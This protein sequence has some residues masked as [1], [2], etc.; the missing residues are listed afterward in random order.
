MDAEQPASPADTAITAATTAPSSP[1]QGTDPVLTPLSKPTWAL[2]LMLAWPV[3]AYQLL[4][5]VVGLSD[6]FL[7]GYFP[8][9]P[10]PQQSEALGHQLMAVGLF[11]APAPGSGVAAALAA[12]TPA[13]AARHIMAKQV[14]YQAAQTT[15]NYLAW[16]R[17]QLHRSGQR[18]QHGPG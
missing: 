7:A 10:L 17:L 2:V 8:Q 5:L 1:T 4:N 16:F 11:G 13:E 6:Q 3:L 15:G 9:V 12:Q 14:A 18:G